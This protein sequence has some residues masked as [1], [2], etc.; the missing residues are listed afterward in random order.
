M[1]HDARRILDANANRAREALRVLEEC[2][3]FLLGHAELAGRCK[4]LR[5]DLA[6]ALQPLAS[7]L[8]SARDAAGD[9]GTAISTASEGERAGARAVAVANA[10]RLTEALR[11]IEEF[12]KTIDPAVSARVEALRYRAYDLERDL[13]LALPTGRM[14]QPKLC[15]LIT[16]SLCTHHP[17]ETVAERALAGGAD[18]LQLREKDLDGGE[19][20]ARA[21]TLVAMA[22]AHGALMIVNDR[23]DV[24]LAAGADGVH[25]GQGDLPLAD[26]RA[27]AGDRLLIGVSTS[28]LDQAVAA[29][30]GGADYC[31]VGPMFPTTTKHKPA[32]AGLEAIRRYAEHDPA[33]PAHL[34]IGGI[35]PENIEGVLD[36]GAAGVAVSG[37]VCSAD[38]PRGM[39]EKLAERIGAGAK[40]V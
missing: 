12:G 6:S 40:R 7:T 38:D 35:T 24:A 4:A 3:R 13:L 15:V 37:C 17:W 10:K 16:A 39:C 11:A 2:A 30:R 27:L 36:A 5:H 26:A 8:A 33:L 34:A 31:G 32:I 23:V 9:V 21:R 20:V 25:L 19:L 22:R 28:T 14:V 18:M 1:T 29:K